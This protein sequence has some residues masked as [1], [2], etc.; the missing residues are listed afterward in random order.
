LDPVLPAVELAA[1]GAAPKGRRDALVGNAP[2]N[3]TMA[4]TRDMSPS[5][6]A[7]TVGELCSHHGMRQIHV[8]KRK[9][10]ALR[11]LRR[12]N[13]LVLE[14]WSKD[15]ITRVKSVEL[16]FN[17]CVIF[18]TGAD[19]FHRYP[20][21]ADRSNAAVSETRISEASP[22]LERPAIATART[23]PEVYL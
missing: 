6:S 9:N 7:T 10:L 4:A 1:T 21:L 23:L 18:A 5:L 12:V 16:L 8:A 15:M 13:V 14:L 20:R 22:A 19:S 17:R 3:G 2:A 11:F